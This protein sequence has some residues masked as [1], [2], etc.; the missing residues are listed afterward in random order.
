M[1]EYLCTRM[2]S[3]LNSEIIDCTD[4][5]KVYTYADV[6]ELVNEYG[7]CL[8]STIPKG[9]KCA[10]LCESEFNQAI[11]ILAAWSANLIPIPMSSQYGSDHCKKIINLTRPDMLITDNEKNY[12]FADNI[13]IYN[14]ST[15]KCT[16]HFATAQHDEGLCECSLIM[17]TSGTTGVPK[18]AVISKAGLINNIKAICHYFDVSN[19]D[20][21]LITRPLYHCAAMTGEFLTALVCGASIVFVKSAYAP[22]KIIEHIEQNKITVMCSTPTLFRHLSLFAINGR[23]ALS[24]SKIAL[25]GECLSKE[26]AC[27]IRKAFPTSKIYNVYGLTECSPR[28]CYLEPTQFDLIPE[29]VGVPVLGVEIKILDEHLNELK[30]NE[31]GYIYVKSKSLMQGYYNNSELTHNVIIDGWLKTGDIGYKDE[32]GYLYVLSRADDMINKGG[33]NIYPSEIENKLMELEQIKE[34]LAY[35]Y[36]KMI[37]SR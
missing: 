36:K 19:K 1:W 21:F 20:T 25:S 31:H 12:E 24:L 30:Y 29:S 17:C 27:I 7:T 37:R 22:Q 33:M 5:K 2:K 28:V 3:N 15:L 13:S 18:G 35:G 26:S 32:K 4:T 16:Q 34:C 8:K 9:S 23:R 10:I 11:S 6:I 14:S